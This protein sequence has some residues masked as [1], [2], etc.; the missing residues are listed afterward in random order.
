MEQT[1]TPA[2]TFGVVNKA[3][4]QKL[5]SPHASAELDE[6]IKPFR[7]RKNPAF[8]GLLPLGL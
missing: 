5:L 4:A 1:V 7:R 2:Q 8:A 3:G 6:A